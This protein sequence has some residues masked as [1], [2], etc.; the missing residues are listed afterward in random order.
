MIIRSVF[1]NFIPLFVHTDKFWTIFFQK[2]QLTPIE[3]RTL[4]FHWV[5]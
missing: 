2:K 5:N 4:I 3:S 1:L